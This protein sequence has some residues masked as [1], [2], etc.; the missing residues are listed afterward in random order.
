[1]LTADERKNF[2]TWLSARVERSGVSKS[3]LSKDWLG[4]D[5]TQRLN[6]YLSGAKIPTLPV[7]A[8]I[9]GAIGGS[10]MVALWRAG[11]FR[12]V[13]ILLDSLSQ[14][15]ETRDDAITLAMW[16]FPTGGTGEPFS[17]DRDFAIETNDSVRRAIGDDPMWFD[18]LDKVDARRELHPLLWYAA[19]QLAFADVEPHTRRLAAAVYVNAWA[20]KLSIDSANRAREAVHQADRLIALLRQQTI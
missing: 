7:L 15:E 18:A 1:L 2:G 14:I 19:D 13:L 5:S 10:V 11:Y 9:I 17:V 3:A 6:R 20:D 16:A 8:K 4:D 12:E